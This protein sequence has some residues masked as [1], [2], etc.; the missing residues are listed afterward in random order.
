M[1]SK[2]TQSEKIII[3]DSIQIRQVQRTFIETTDITSEMENVEIFLD[4]VNTAL[5]N[6]QL[7]EAFDSAVTR[8]RR[9]TLGLADTMHAVRQRSRSVADGSEPVAPR[10]ETFDLQS[11]E[12]KAPDATRLQAKVRAKNISGYNDSES[13][14]KIEGAPKQENAAIKKD[15]EEKKDDLD[16]KSP[17][18]NNK[19]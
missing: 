19:M 9:D 13:R 11:K 10:R 2:I 6:A 17:R 18:T 4:R 15:S 5:A 7:P 12:I 16:K 1:E 8:T 3:G 14:K